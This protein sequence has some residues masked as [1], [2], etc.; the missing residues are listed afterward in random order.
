MEVTKSL[1]H[2]RKR[3]LRGVRE[4]IGRNMSEHRESFEKGNAD[5]DPVEFWGRLAFCGKMSPSPGK[6][7]VILPAGDSMT[8]PWSGCRMR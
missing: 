2:F 8:S 5:A 7:D 4:H 3:P 1:K 6:Q